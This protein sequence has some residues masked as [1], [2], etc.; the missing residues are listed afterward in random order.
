MALRPEPLPHRATPGEIDY[1]LSRRRV[2]ADLRSGRLGRE[3]VCDAHPEL[4]RAGAEVGAPTRQVCP[5]CG[6]A[7]LR[8]VTYVFGPR[9]PAHGRCI[10]SARELV[11]IGERKGEFAAYVV[12][13][14]PP[15]GWHHLVRAYVLGSG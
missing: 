1:R 9:L 4:R 11:R 8:H 6:D 13:V 5:V 10:T 12:E 7:E 2:I 14:C 15:C 3:D